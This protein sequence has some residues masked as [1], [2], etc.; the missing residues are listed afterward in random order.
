MPPAPQ[1]SC[2]VLRCHRIMRPAV[3]MRCIGVDGVG[4]L[5]S[6]APRVL[7]FLVPALVVVFATPVGLIGFDSYAGLTDRPCPS[8]VVVS[9]GFLQFAGFFV[10]AFMLKL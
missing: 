3:P 7:L 4:Y 6:T 9:P 10:R 8:L 2:T 5:R 1:P